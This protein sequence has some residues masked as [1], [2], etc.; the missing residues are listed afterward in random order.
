MKDKK[1]LVVED[2]IIFKPHRYDIGYQPWK[3]TE[4]RENLY[5]IMWQSRIRY[6]KKRSPV[7]VPVESEAA[8]QSQFEG[9]KAKLANCDKTWENLQVGEYYR[10]YAPCYGGQDG[11]VYYKITDKIP[12]TAEDQ[13]YLLRYKVFSGRSNSARPGSRSVQSP[14]YRIWGRNFKHISKLEGMIIV[15]E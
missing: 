9:L 12:P 1:N 15:G 3:V 5:V 10:R 13:C 8:M 2:Q 14:K 6:V 4:V 11:F 7:F